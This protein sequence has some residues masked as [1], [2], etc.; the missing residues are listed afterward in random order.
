MIDI[1]LLYEGYKSLV[2]KD[3]RVEE[4]ALKRLNEC[5]RCKSSSSII[6]YHC[7]ECGCYI[8]AKVRSISSRCPLG[9]WDKEVI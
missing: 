9:K 4:I 7:I 2:I 6:Y 3:S 5:S 8:P 1:N